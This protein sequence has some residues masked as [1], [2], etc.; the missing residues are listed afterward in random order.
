MEFAFKER[1]LS[2]FKVCMNGVSIDKCQ[3]I[4]LYNCSELDADLLLVSAVSRTAR[5]ILV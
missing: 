5:S 4:W 1:E 3:V 2:K